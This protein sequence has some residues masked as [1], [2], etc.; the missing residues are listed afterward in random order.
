MKKSAAHCSIQN[1]CYLAFVEN[2][3]FNADSLKPRF[4]EKSVTQ[5]KLAMK[6]NTLQQEY[7]LSNLHIHLS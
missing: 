4:Y 2:V 7:P 1:E 5:A 3:G 6:T